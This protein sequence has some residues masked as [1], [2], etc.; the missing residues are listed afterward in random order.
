M[1]DS[2]QLGAVGIKF[3]E[4]EG[5][6]VSMNMFDCASTPLYRTFELVNKRLKVWSGRYR[7]RISR[8]SEIRLFAKQFRILFGITRVETRPNTRISSNGI[9]I[10]DLP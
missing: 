2:L 7:F 5:V 10:V 3:P 8:T 6:V 1:A 4:R 9:M